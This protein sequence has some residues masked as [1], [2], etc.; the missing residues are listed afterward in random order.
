VT[1]EYCDIEG[2]W[3]G[4]GNID[5][6]PLFVN[7]A[8]GDFRLRMDSPCIDAG[9]N[10][11]PD[12][13][14]ADHEGDDRV[15]DGDLDGLAVVD[16][17]ADEEILHVAARFGMVN[18]GAGDLADVVFVNGSSGD[19]QRVV[20]IAPTDPL[21]VSVEVP[22]AGPAPAPFVLYAWKGQPGDA[23]PTMHPKNLGCMCFPT[24]WRGGSPQPRAIWN[25]LGHEAYLGASTHVSTPAPSTPLD[26][27][28]GVGQPFTMTFQGFI[29]DNASA[30]TQPASITNGVVV[31][32]E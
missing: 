25:N 20:R 17:G 22:P 28:G 14:L 1:F 7:A 15:I 16:I 6:D 2:G 4:E 29:R 5:A 19:A 10:D 21:A 11:A 9:T 26:R 24:P 3:A 8:A 13:P 23:T 27:P 32:V 31:V 18:A 12:L 30:S